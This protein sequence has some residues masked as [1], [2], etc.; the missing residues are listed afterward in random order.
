MSGRKRNREYRD[1]NRNAMSREQQMKCWLRRRGVPMREQEKIVFIESAWATAIPSW[2]WQ[3]AD[4][5]G[6]TFK[7]IVTEQFLGHCVNDQTEGEVEKSW[8]LGFRKPFK[9]LITYS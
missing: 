7:S 5:L 1:V 8:D 6:Y 4:R 3:A 2:I 9:E